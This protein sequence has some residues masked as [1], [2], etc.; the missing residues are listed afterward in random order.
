MKQKVAEPTGIEEKGYSP[1]NKLVQLLKIDR[2]PVSHTSETDPI[3]QREISEERLA[4]PSTSRS[5]KNTNQ[6]IHSQDAGALDNQFKTTY[7][8]HTQS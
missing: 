4:E 3:S 7:P 2:H 1:L 8:F 5:Y 6:Y